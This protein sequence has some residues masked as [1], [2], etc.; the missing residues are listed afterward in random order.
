[1]ELVSDFFRVSNYAE[2]GLWFAIAAAVL[3]RFGMTRVAVFAAITL[4]FFGV[5]DIV[6]ATTGAWWRPWW[7]F[8]WKTF[9]VAT[10][11]G[12]FWAARKKRV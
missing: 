8:A 10:L 6:E 7:L 1:L 2:S 4:V 12:V 11:A 5:S 9:C 3:F